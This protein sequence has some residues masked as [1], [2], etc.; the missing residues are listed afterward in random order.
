MGDSAWVLYGGLGG[1]GTRETMDRTNHRITEG[2]KWWFDNHSKTD[3]VWLCCD[4]TIFSSGSASA[5]ATKQTNILR[6][7]GVT[8]TIPV[9]L[10]RTDYGKGNYDFIRQ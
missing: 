8:V 3:I 9:A 2:V 6:G 1:G 7:K 5:Q 10:N 4:G